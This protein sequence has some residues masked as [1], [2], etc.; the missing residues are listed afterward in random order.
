MSSSARAQ[1][2]PPLPAPA[3]G[4]RPGGGAAEAAK[5]GAGTVEERL[6][7]LEEQNRLLAEQNRKLLERLEA[8]SGQYQNLNER[9][10]DGSGE[11]GEDTSDEGGAGARDNP[12]G[13]DAPGSGG[14]PPALPDADEDTSD[15]GGAGARDNPPERTGARLP[16]K[17]Y[18]GP[19]FEWETDGGEF[20]L[21]FHNE[22]QVEYRQFDHTGQGTVHDGFFLPR[23][24]WAFAGRITK[25]IEY[26]TSLQKG[27]GDVNVR[28]AFLNFRYDER[29]MVKAGRYKVPFT[30]E[31]YAISNQD[32]MAPERSLFSINFGDNRELGVMAWGEVLDGRLDYAAGVFNGPRSS[33]ED[34][35]DAKDVIA[36]VNARPFGKS[37]RFAFLKHLNVG[38]SVDAG[39]QENPILP[40]AL[41]TAVNAGQS[42]GTSTAAPAFLIFNDNIMESGL[43]AMWNL[44]LAYFYN[45]L[46]LQA[47]WN[48]GFA[49]YAPESD[50]SQRTR[51]P[52]QGYYVQAGYFLTGESVSRRTQVDILRP[53]SLK[54]GEFGLGA[55]EVQARFA[56]LNLGRQVFDGGL[57]DPNLWSND[58]YAVDA[59]LNWY[60]NRYVKVY[61]D[62]QH[63]EFGEPVIFGP[64]QFRRSSNLYW[65]RLQIYF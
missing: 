47:E 62:W 63:S 17:G 21:Q 23:Q 30:Y 58:A 28:D 22:T 45:G 39:R 31:Y 38:G 8:L 37:E 16:I 4:A 6:R 14:L 53:F 9:V 65:I 36:Y 56:G 57:A 32:L 54:P 48:S 34:V 27:F 3:A 46:S 20:Q 24:I 52:V 15:E 60:L 51:V 13:D 1:S 33:F 29:F 49:S 64:D 59:G 42:S 11:S 19:G 55:F 40:Q 35:N 26:F 2:L 7:R 61:L 44:H 12:A 18:F 25:P 5:P 43:R 50:L 41:R 10:G